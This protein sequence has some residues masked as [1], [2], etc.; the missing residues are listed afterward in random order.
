MRAFGRRKVRFVV[1]GV[2][3]ANYYGQSAG[4]LFTT[5][6]RDLFLPRDPRNLL[7]AWEVC[8]DA[9]LE[10]WCGD[11]PLD[12][13]RDL[14]L[15]QRI[16]ERSVLVRAEAAE[17]LIDLSPVMAGFDFEAVWE[18]R[19]QFVVHGVAIPVARLSDIVASKAAAGRLKDRLFLA[20]HE[21]ALRA[22][23]RRRL[24]RRP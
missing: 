23:G 24:G 1:I 19:R 11:E 4:L 2:S 22:L 13:P 12:R 17:L 5:E 7:R 6:D 9:G 18:R 3:G 10:L 21:D 20:A 15:A 14:P 8:Q 16:L